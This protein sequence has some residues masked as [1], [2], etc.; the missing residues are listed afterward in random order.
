MYIILDVCKDAA[1]M[2]PNGCILCERC[3]GVYHVRIKVS[4][5]LNHQLP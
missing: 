4:C 5:G 3:S 2:R 1:R